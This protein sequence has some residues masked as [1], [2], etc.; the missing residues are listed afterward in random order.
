MAGRVERAITW[1]RL[2]DDQRTQV[3]DILD[4]AREQI[5]RLVAEATARGESPR[6]IEMKVRRLVLDSRNRVFAVL[7]PA[8]RDAFKETFDRDAGP[9]PSPAP[10]RP[11]LPADD[12]MAG[13]SMTGKRHDER[14]TMSGG[15]KE[16]TMG[17]RDGRHHG[18]GAMSGGERQQAQRPRVP[19]TLPAV[20]RSRSVRR[21]PPSPCL[22]GSQAADRQAPA[23]QAPPSSSSAASVTPSFRDQMPRLISLSKT[24][25][26]SVT[27]LAVYTREM[28]PADGAQPQRN[29]SDKISMA[30]HRSAD[31][32]EAAARRRRRSSASPS[33]SCPMR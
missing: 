32:R 23:G 14:R 5:D 20:L 1:L 27:W 19:T 13:T 2:T 15:T 8:Q 3:F 10:L 22:G 33:T 25:G 4:P 29:A 30:A 26:S 16:G 12:A 9:A 11:V 17:G 24:H 28:H 6:E 18:R 21:F 31:Q 7:P